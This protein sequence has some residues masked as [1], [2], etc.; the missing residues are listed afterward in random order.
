MGKRIVCL[1]AA[2]LL[3][4]SFVGCS[5]STSGS[6]SAANEP[7]ETAETTETEGGEAE[8]LG[9][10]LEKI[11]ASGKL[12]VGVEA[13]F[14]PFESYD[15]E[16]GTTIV[17]FDIDLVQEIA[18]D[19]GVELEIRDMEFAGIVP[20]VQSGKI[21]LAPCITRTDERALVVAFSGEYTSSKLGAVIREDDDTITTLEELLEKRVSV[22][23][24]SLADRQVTANGIT[25][26]GYNKHD[27][28]LLNVKNGMEDAHILDGTVGN[29]YA[30]SLGG[31]K[32]VEIPE[33][34]EGVPGLSC[35]VPLGQDALL[36][37]VNKTIERLESSGEMDALRAKWN[38][39]A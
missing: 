1:M 8:E 7:A 25:P 14:P 33:L 30:Q 17:G 31:L 2:L 35:I 10:M 32:V 39:F 15:V 26:K 18:N 16:T 22:Q 21:D 20:S 9:D 34:N 38:L 5:S 36:A 24:G 28:A 19:L 23:L 37:E 12:V 3:V 27:E 6:S 13:T 11:K 4:V 29:Q